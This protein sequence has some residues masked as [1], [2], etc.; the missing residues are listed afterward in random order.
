M[1]EIPSFR[2]S[3]NGFHRGDVINFIK[4][5]LDENAFLTEILSRVRE[6]NSA[7][8]AEI[9]SCREQIEGF[10]TDRQNEQVLGRA[11]YDVRRF[12]D[13]RVREANDQAKAIMSDAAAAAEDVSSQV[14]VI[15]EQTGAFE[16]C[17]NESIASVTAQ[18][19]AL[20]DLLDVFRKDVAEKSTVFVKPDDFE[21]PKKADQTETEDAESAE[22]EDGETPVPEDLEAV[23]EE[24]TLPEAPETEEESTPAPVRLTVKKVKRSNGKK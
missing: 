2:T 5:I 9:E 14:D 11:M 22:T 24:L 7:L 16:A 18:M 12:S 20:R 19:T 3:I 23:E 10:H 6:E 8:Q 17:F 13:E 21:L 1:A 4:K 15:A